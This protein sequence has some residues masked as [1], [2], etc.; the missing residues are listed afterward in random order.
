MTTEKW[1]HIRFGKKHYIETSNGAAHELGDA[2]A[3]LLLHLD[4]DMIRP[5][6]ILCIGTD[7]STGDC[8]GPLVGTQLLPLASSYYHIYGTLDDPIHATNLIERKKAIEEAHPNGIMIAIDASLGT[9]D[10][11]GKISIGLGSLRPGAGVKKIS[12]QWEICISPV[13]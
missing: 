12:L 7:R 5:R 3:E 9:V 10:Q 8:L 2:L 4:P 13:S 11:V 6:V 1:D